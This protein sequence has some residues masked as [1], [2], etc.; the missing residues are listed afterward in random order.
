MKK[1][2]EIYQEIAIPMMKEKFNYTNNLAIP[3]LT[4]ISINTGIGKL[5]EDKKTIEAIAK[6]LEKITGQRPSYC[7]AKKSIS[8]FKLRKGQKIGLKVTL[9]SKR[10]YDFLERL[11][12]I[13]LPRIRDFRGLSNKSFDGSGNYSLGIKEQSVFPEIEYDE[14]V[15]VHP[16]QITI[17]TSAKNN[18]EA[19]ELLKLLGLPFTK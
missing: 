10:M 13:V 3:K 4:K 1:I 15:I 18:E 19:A 6:D 12:N 5:A 11:T 8:G 2:K 14:M 16:L 7:Q 17:T 9:R